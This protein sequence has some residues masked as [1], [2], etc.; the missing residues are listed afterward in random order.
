MR[1]ILEHLAQEGHE[2]TVFTSQPS[3]ND[4]RQQKRPIKEKVGGIYLF[5]MPLLWEKKSLFFTRLLNSFLFMAGSFL[6]GLFCKKMQLAMAPSTPPVMMGAT[7]RWL[8]KMKRCKYIYHCQD[9]QP[10]V[11]LVGGQFSRGWIY[12]WM[13]KVERRTVKNASSAIVLSRDMARAVKERG[14][15]GENIKVLNN[16]IL[17]RFQK[18]SIPSSLS[19][20]KSKFRVLFTGNHG[21]YQ[22]LC[23]VIQAAK[24]LKDYSGIVFQFVGEGLAK[25]SMM[26][27]AGELVGETVFFHSYVMPET[28]FNV[29]QEGD[30]GLV[31][32][33]PE[34][35][36]YA[37]PSKT[38]MLLAAGLPLMVVVEPHSELAGFVSENGL[39]WVPPPE[40][41]TALADNILKAYRTWKGGD[42]NFD[43]IPSV[44]EQEF[45]IKPNL[46]RWSNL[47]AELE[48]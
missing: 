22:G 24:L 47:I 26:E 8:S 17:D 11:G 23:H 15:A 3:Y 5:R 18:G 39:G 6:Y 19:K 14:I 44:A 25:E 28:I 30:L 7:L 12:D 31:T 20:P 45:G 40:D 9:L 1:L 46:R 10:E 16:F 4:I 29:L 2:I 35:Y 34:V 48:K 21:V 13:Y 42:W 36:R 38:M 41:A 33:Q 27:Q 43:H 37:Y 32:L